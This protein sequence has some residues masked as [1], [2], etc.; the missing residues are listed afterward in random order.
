M[1]SGE[2][3][4]R[5]ATDWLILLADDPNDLA[6]RRAF[7]AWL[8][9]DPLHGAAWEATTRTSAVLDRATPRH[10][11]QWMPLLADV[12]A[13][14]KRRPVLWR[15]WAVAGLA[16][17][18]CL[19]ALVA[20]PDLATRLR[21][22][23]V[24]MTAEVRVVPLPDG[25]RAILAPE[26]AIALSYGATERRVRLLAGEALFEVAKDPDRPFRVTA[27]RVSV[28]ALGT[29]FDLRRDG[30]ETAV[31]VDHG[32]VRVEHEGVPEPLADTLTAGQALRI[33]G[34]GVVS[35]NANPIPWI[36]AWRDGRVI[37]RDEPLGEVVDRLRPYF[38]GKIV[39]TD[40]ALAAEPVT[41]VYDPTDPLEALRAIARARDAVVRRLGPWLI[42][43]SAS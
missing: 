31:A 17:A 8:D 34:E 38:S 28:T 22:D 7:E 43:V 1:V 32:V 42:L 27:G 21:A 12:R 24:S 29:A 26:S 18:A 19:V 36:A 41:G 5:E 33:D 39:V 3:A 6:T 10:E 14:A 20:G 30:E 23:H 13:R 35:R 2:R 11:N 40:R 16:A 4:S 25:G 9:R 15:R 37:A